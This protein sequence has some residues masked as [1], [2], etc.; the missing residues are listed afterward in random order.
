MSRV[1][2]PGIIKTFVLAAGVG[3]FLPVSAVRR[4]RAGHRLAPDLEAPLTQTL[5]THVLPVRDVGVAIAH[6]PSLVVK[7]VGV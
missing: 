1:A 5:Q 4:G 6:L 7:T 3:D 2:P